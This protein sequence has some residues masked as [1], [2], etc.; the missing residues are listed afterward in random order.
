MSEFSE[1]W[2]TGAMQRFFESLDARFELNKADDPASQYRNWRFEDPLADAI[3]DARFAAW[4][5][6]ELDQYP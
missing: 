2:T 6:G 4:V 3:N 1:R 5:R